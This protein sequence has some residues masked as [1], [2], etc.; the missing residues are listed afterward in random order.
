MASRPQASGNESALK[1][2]QAAFEGFVA[3]ERGMSPNTL[4][5]YSRDVRRFADFLAKRKVSSCDAISR[6]DLADYLAD[7]Q[8]HYKASSSRARAWAAVR[9]FLKFAA[10]R[11]YAKENPSALFDTPK[12]S[13]PLPRTLGEDAVARLVESVSGTTPRDL[14]DRAILELFYACGLRVSE[15]CD[16]SLDGFS[17]DAELLRCFGKGS[18]ERV[19]PIGSKAAQALIRYIH[20]ARDVFAKGNAAE[21]H[22]FLTR[23]G[24]R[25]TRE[26]IAAMLRKRAIA[27]GLDPATISPHVLRH[28]FASHLLQHGADI[29]AIQEMLGHASVATTQIYTHIDTSRFAEA[30]KRF[31]PR[32]E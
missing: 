14:R 20:C 12:R 28:S 30:H 2:A 5:A 23:N 11:G 15:L 3:L 9:G 13:Q 10:A 21:R 16:L 22:L 8:H 32:A 29:R 27:A 26:G 7:L 24:G 1:A 25:F 4:E 31:H 18:K 19:V 17:A 6:K